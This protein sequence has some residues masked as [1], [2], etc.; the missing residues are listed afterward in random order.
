VTFAGRKFST[1][2]WWYFFTLDG[3]HLVVTDQMLQFRATMIRFYYN[4]GLI[5]SPT[6]LSGGRSKAVRHYV[7]K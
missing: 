2:T 7:E 1:G 6:D 5:Q 4:H 3:L